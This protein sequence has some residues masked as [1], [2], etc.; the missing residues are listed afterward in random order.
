MLLPRASTRS[1]NEQILSIL[2]RS[3]SVFL[4]AS[5][6]PFVCLYPW[7]PASLCGLPSIGAIGIPTPTAQDLVS[8][9][10]FFTSFYTLLIEGLWQR[11]NVILVKLKTRL[12]EANSFKK[13]SLTSTVPN[14]E[15]VAIRSTRLYVVLLIVGMVVLALFNGL[16]E[17]TVSQTV[18]NPSLDTFERLYATYSRTLSCPC[19]TF[20]ISYGAFLSM[21][22]TYHQVCLIELLPTKPSHCLGLF[23]RIHQQNVDHT[24]VWLRR[25]GQQLFTVG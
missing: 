6:S 12:L 9:P 3:S 14:A 1:L 22:P 21:T 13:E 10:I 25:L 24:A 2:S 23:E 4:V 11:M 19:Q 8:L 20:S 18:P 16:S 5:S 7:L 17:T 15:Q